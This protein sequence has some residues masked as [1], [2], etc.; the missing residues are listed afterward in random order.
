[1]QKS[2]KKNKGKAKFVILLFIRTV[3]V[4]AFISS[5]ISGRKLV[6]IMSILGFFLTYAPSIIKELFN[7][8]VPASFE[9]IVIF[10]IYGIF[11]F[12]EVR[13]LYAEFWWWDIILNLLSATALGFIGLAVLS[14]LKKEKVI[15]ANDKIIA[16]LVFCFAVSIG[17]LL[18]FFEFSMDSLFNFNMQKSAMDTMKDIGVNIVGALLISTLGYYHFKTGKF[19]IISQGISKNVGKYSSFFKSSEQLD[20]HE[21]NILNLL[22]KG[23][24]FNLEFKSTLRKNLHTHEHDKK[25]EHAVLKTLTAYLNSDGGT[26]LVGVND[27]GEILGLAHDGFAD[28]D[29]LNLYF[30]NLIKQ[31]IGSEYLPFIKYE[32]KNIEG[33][34]ILKIDC[35]KSHKHVF[36]KHEGEEEFYIRNGA[37]SAKLTGNSLVDY[38]NNKFSKN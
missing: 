19:D 13:G 35:N 33:K 18:E 30:T 16:I 9:V 7:K 21:N 14:V 11:Y 10:F 26:L 12:G 25:I 34:N 24:G 2:G 27:S 28:N 1:M 15:N 20:T 37:S 36:L 29:K 32:I 38:I 31:H 22:K 4:L 5:L 6:L 8:E 23:E 17:A 3:L